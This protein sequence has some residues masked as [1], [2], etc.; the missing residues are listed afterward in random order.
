[1]N[2]LL[3]C[4]GQEEKRKSRLMDRLKELGSFLRLTCHHPL[5]S[6]IQKGTITPFW[7]LAGEDTDALLDDIEREEEEKLKA[8]AQGGSLSPVS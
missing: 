6:F 3:V 7:R 8:L 1:M 5:H 2:D 4:L